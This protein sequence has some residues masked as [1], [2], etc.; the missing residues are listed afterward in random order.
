MDADVDSEMA[1]QLFGLSFYYAAAVMVAQALAT[2]VVVATIAVYGSSFFFSSAAADAAA[3][4]D[5]SSVR[6]TN[7][8]GFIRR[9]FFSY[10]NSWICRIL[11]LNIYPSH[12]S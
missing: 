4:M 7:G 10:L 5:V 1:I 8:D 11:V 3:I 6:N 2:M 12:I 9:L